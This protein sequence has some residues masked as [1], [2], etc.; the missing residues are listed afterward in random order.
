MFLFV[1]GILFH[2][3]FILYRIRSIH[4]LLMGNAADIVVVWREAIRVLF[5]LKKNHA[6]KKSQI[7]PQELGGVP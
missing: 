3:Y 2:A 4:T 7:F 5:R 6:Y 1:H